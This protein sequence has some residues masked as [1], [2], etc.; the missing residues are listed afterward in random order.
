MDSLDSVVV[1]LYSSVLKYSF[2][3]KNVSSAKFFRKVLLHAMIL[4][5]HRYGTRSSLIKKYTLHQINNLTLLITCKRIVGKR[6]NVGTSI[7]MFF[8]NVFFL[9]Y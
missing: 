5:G 2:L 8:H 6:E 9:P 3:N 4:K 1:Y 7:F